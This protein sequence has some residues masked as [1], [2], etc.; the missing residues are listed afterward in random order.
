[1]KHAGPDAL[2]R[3]PRILE[4]LRAYPQLKEK[5]LG[6][7]YLKARA[8][9]HF[10]EDRAGLFADVRSANDGDF[11]RFKV[12]DSTGAEALFL[13]VEGQLSRLS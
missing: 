3:L 13:F 11:D 6:V 12:D 9:L 8:F 10:H 4:R 7:F 1:M 5:S 2:A